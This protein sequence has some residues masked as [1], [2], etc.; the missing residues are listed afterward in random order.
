V[1]AVALLLLCLC[2]GGGHGWRACGCLSWGG[3][4][5]AALVIG[6]WGVQKGRQMQLDEMA[7]S[8]RNGLSARIACVIFFFFFLYPLCSEADFLLSGTHSIIHSTALS[9]V[10]ISYSR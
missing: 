5:R 6:S 3:R 7:G 8:H 1:V 4:G 2:C 10:D 9:L